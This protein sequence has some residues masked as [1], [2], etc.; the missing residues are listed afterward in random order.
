[1]VPERYKYW[2]NQALETFRQKHAQYGQ[3][4]GILSLPSFVD[5]LTIKAHRI[6][7]L[8][9]SGGKAATGEP[10]LHDW[11]ALVNYA[12]LALL[13]QAPS[14]TPLPEALQ[15][16]FHQAETLLA[17]KNA[18]YGDAWKHM[19]PLTF[20][21]LILMKL[22]RLRQLDKD[23]VAHRTAIRDNLFDILNYALLYLSAY[24]DAADT[25]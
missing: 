4:W 11:I 7:T 13:E 21:E 17:Q 6:H 2:Q 10:P 24:G 9:Q 25:P 22:A 18:D 16:T 20:I 3:S 23:P 19:R 8:L 14:T 1:M 15:N 12:A 5:L